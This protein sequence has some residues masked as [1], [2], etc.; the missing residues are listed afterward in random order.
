VAVA[1]VEAVNVTYLELLQQREVLVLLYYL[2]QQQ[3]IQE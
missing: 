3:A 2:Y 1:E